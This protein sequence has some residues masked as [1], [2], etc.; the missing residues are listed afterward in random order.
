MAAVDAVV[1]VHVVGV[2][3]DGPDG[4]AE[5][6]GDLAV[7]PAGEEQLLDLRGVVTGLG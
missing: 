1:G 2:T 4:D 5:F 6:A 7:G 3:G